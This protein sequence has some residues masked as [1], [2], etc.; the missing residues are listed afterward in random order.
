MS[1][2][3]PKIVTSHVFPSIPV[4]HFDWIAHYDGEEESGCYGNGRTEQEAIDDLLNHF[5]RSGQPCRHCDG[6]VFRDGET[7]GKGGCPFGGDF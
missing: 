2:T 5:A 3:P 4:R 6:R 7:C 1:T